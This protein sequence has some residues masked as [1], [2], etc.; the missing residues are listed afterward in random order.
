MSD[1]RSSA[2][3]LENVVRRGL[4][5]GLLARCMAYPDEE[6]VLALHDMATAAAP[7][8]HG[9]TLS[10]LV[11]ATITV[12]RDEIEPEYTKLVTLSSSPDCPSF[13]TAFFSPDPVQ[14]TTRMADVAGF[15]RAFGVDVGGTRLRPDEISV[16]LEFMA[17]LC[18]KQVYAYEHFG[19]PRVRQ[20]TRAQRLFLTE[21]LGTWGGALGQRMV[22][23]AGSEFYREVGGALATWIA[24]DCAAL[25]ATP[26]ATS[27]PSSDWDTARSADTSE[28][29]AR[30]LELND[31]MTM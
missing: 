13:E 20:A 30:L 8:L 16:E 5:Y 27:A 19:A 12:R 6:H 23:R 1:A 17:Y 29:E 3:T 11:A 21:H 31:V 28:D 7:A 25:G 15:Y 24:E 10:S 4:A 14:Q 2:A 26:L 18:K 9:S 22:L